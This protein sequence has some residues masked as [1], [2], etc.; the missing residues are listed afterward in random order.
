LAV[1]IMAIFAAGSFGL[2]GS[3][4][5]AMD[6]SRDHYVAVNLA[7]NRMEWLRLYPVAQLSQLREREVVLNEIGTADSSGNFRR[8]TSANPLNTNLWDVTISVAVR[9]R[10]T[11]LFVTNGQET[12]RTYLTDFI[13]PPSS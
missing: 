6:G 12:I 10:T 11:G 4:R 2:V 1:F 8:T 13:A 5:E 3:V 9:D 7:K